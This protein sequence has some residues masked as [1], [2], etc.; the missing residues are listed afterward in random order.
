MKSELKFIIL[1]IKL[2]TMV[3]QK[4]ADHGKAGG[5]SHLLSEV[6]PVVPDLPE[7]VVLLEHLREHILSRVYKWKD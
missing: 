2:N 4:S 7:I 1:L 3:F 6:P 5:L